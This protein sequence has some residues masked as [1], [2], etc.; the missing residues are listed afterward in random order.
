[1]LFTNPIPH[2]SAKGALVARLRGRDQPLFEVRVEPIAGN[3]EEIC[4]IAHW[5]NRHRL[6]LLAVQ[7]LKED[8]GYPFTIGP[9]ADRESPLINK[10]PL[11]G[12]ELCTFR[13]SF[14][15]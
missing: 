5:A 7:D 1:M 15:G 4:E 2:I 10:A 14:M 11:A 8:V 6:G 12:R 3:L 13:R 9:A